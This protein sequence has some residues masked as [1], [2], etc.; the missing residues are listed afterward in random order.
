MPSTG[1][2]LRVQK[3][4]ILF[5]SDENSFLSRKKVVSCYGEADFCRQVLPLHFQLK[6]KGKAGPGTFFRF[7]LDGPVM[8]VDDFPAGVEADTGTFSLHQFFTLETGE[9]FKETVFLIGR[10]AGT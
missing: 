3:L 9:S 4:S 6:R 1:R 8:Q 2:A 5:D 7:A 10:K